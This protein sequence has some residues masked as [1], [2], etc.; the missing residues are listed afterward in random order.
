MKNSIELV[1]KE[2][3]RIKDLGSGYAYKSDTKMA[4]KTYSRFRYNGVVFIVDDN[5]PFVKD[6]RNGNVHT[7]WLTSGTRETIDA[8]GN[9]IE[10]PEYQ[11]ES[12]ISN[13]QIIGL[14]KTNAVL[15]AITKGSFKPEIEISEDAL[16]EL[17]GA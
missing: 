14:T 3:F 13:A 5:D 6:F 2:I 8:E 16:K 12:H 7:I 9:T 11:F 10:V 15:D 17:E 4:G 1:G